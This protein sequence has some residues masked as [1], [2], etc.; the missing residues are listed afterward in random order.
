MREN[1][2]RTDNYG[3]NVTKNYGQGNKKVRQFDNKNATGTK[4]NKNHFLG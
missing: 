4:L 3:N 2:K 1:N